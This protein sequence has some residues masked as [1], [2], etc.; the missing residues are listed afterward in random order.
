MHK[1]AQCKYNSIKREI[2]KIKKLQVRFSQPKI[3][4]FFF[5]YFDTQDLDSLQNFS[6]FLV[7][8]WNLPWR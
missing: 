2:K 1:N 8:F 5:K 7:H 4:E 3:T 6:I